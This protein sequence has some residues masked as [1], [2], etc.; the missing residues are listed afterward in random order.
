MTMEGGKPEARKETPSHTFVQS[1]DGSLM[2]VKAAVTINPANNTEEVVPKLSEE[3]SEDL[4]E[5]K[6]DLH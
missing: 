4:K 5:A 3:Q 1:P 2:E 6:E